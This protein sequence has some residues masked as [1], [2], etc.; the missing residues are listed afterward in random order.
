MA[1]SIPIVTLAQVKEYLGLKDEYDSLDTVLDTAST[2]WIDLAS[3][4]IEEYLGT[5]VYS[6]SVTAY[7]NG[8]GGMSQDVPMSPIVSIT[9]IQYRTTF[10]GTWTDLFTSSDYYYTDPLTDPFRITGYVDSFPSG[11]RNIKI[12]YNCGWSTI[13]A[14]IQQ[15][16]L[17]MIAMKWKESKKGQDQLGKS[18]VTSS[19]PGVSGSTSFSDMTPRW[20]KILDRYRRIPV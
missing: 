2:G 5:K 19:G 20:M 17:E 13:P 11:E 12:I 16:C 18:S 9:S 1:S 15:V 8:S 14:E 4:A 7:L 3:K 10:N 6:Q